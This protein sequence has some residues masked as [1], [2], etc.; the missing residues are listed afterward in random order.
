MFL[1]CQLG[2]I[3]MINKMRFEFQV[4]FLFFDLF[5]VIFVIPEESKSSVIHN[6]KKD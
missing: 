6:F 1:C 5:K 2:D 4:A 3:M